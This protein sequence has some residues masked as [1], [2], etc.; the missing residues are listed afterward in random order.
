M[1]LVQSARTRIVGVYLLIA[2]LAAAGVYKVLGLP[3][4]IF[5]SVTFPLVRVIIN[6]GDEPAAR[7]MTTVTRPIEE[8][9]LRVPG[10]QSVRSTT[11]R[12]SSEIDAQFGWGTD[13]QVAITQVQSETQRV[14]PT[15]PAETTIDIEW[16]NPA[17]FPIEGY[18]LISDHETLAQLRDYAE[19]TLRPALVRIPGVSQ[20]QIQ[21]G[22]LREFEVR[23][24]P[25][26]LEARRL[27]PS[28]VADA[29]RKQ[30]Q[31]L[32]AGLTERNHELYLTLVDG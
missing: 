27:A 1:K 19:Y 16:M 2:I 5:P 25:R 13:M 18:A 15:L 9:I 22:D 23:L 30:N 11:S 31:V 28:D 29:I 8:S 24:D 12:G 14:R 6:V 3:S 17:V 10:I 4:S 21:G 20:V 32:S 26:A 7:M